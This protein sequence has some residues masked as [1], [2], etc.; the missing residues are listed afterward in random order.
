MKALWNNLRAVDFLETLP[1]VDPERMGVIGHSLGGHQALFTA[2]FDQRLSAVV[3][4]CGFTAFGDYRGGDLTAWSQPRYMPRVATEYGND[5][6]RMPFDFHEVLA[7]IAP[8]AV[9][10]NA[11]LHDDNFA[12]SGVQSV[13]AAVQPVYEQMRSRDGQE[14]VLEVPDC[15]HDFPDDVRTRAYEWLDRVL[16]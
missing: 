15:G 9:F 16:D 14:L 5:P 1:Q 4:S 11:P 3:T 13:V 7:A 8:R 10:V 12:N 6:A 2:A